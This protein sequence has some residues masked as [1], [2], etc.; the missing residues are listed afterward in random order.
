MKNTTVDLRKHGS[1]HKRHPRLG[2]R[3]VVEVIAIVKN[4]T[5]VDFACPSSK[6]TK[7]FHAD[8]LF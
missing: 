8:R 2:C 3:L 6:L 5:I 1:D 4:K 7:V